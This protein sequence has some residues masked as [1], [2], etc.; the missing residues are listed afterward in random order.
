MPKAEQQ[1]FRQLIGTFLWSCLIWMWVER[2]VNPPISTLLKPRTYCALLSPVLQ[3]LTLVFTPCHV[4][5]SSSGLRKH[6]K[7]K[8]V[9]DLRLQ[10]DRLDLLEK[11]FLRLYMLL[12]H[13]VTLWGMLSSAVCLGWVPIWMTAVPHWQ[14]YVFK[15]A[16]FITGHVA[17][18]G[19]WI[20][21]ASTCQRLHYWHQRFGSRQNLRLQSTC[22]NHLVFVPTTWYLYPP[23][24][25]IILR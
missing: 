15:G 5:G 18:P 25:R 3:K 4:F 12:K 21:V 20:T 8:V 9:W 6:P 11:R 14:A 7:V 1:K 22:T 19:D 23:A 13:P 17:I 10:S 24:F 16:V 2:K